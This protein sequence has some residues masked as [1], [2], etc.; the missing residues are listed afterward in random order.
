[1]KALEHL[2]AF[3]IILAE[4]DSSPGVIIMPSTVVGE[5]VGAFGNICA[6]FR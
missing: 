1:M 4:F 3:G 5:G 2:V 6:H